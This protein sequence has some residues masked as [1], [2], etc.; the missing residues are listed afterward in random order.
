[1]IRRLL[2][3]RQRVPVALAIEAAV[4]VAAYLAY[5][6]VRRAIAPHAGP[7]ISHAVRLV[8]FERR[9][10]FFWER[11]LQQAVVDYHLLVTLLNWVYVWGYLPV[12]G[13]VAIWLFVNHR[14]VYSRYRNAFLL[15]GAAGLMVFA[16][17]P[18]APPR[19]LPDGGFV[20]T[21]RLY[22]RIYN[23]IEGSGY[24]NQFAAVPSFHFGWILLVA[25][26]IWETTGNRLLRLAA[27]GMPV[28]MLASIVL[29]GNHYFFDALAGG[30]LVLLALGVVISV[31]RVT[32][33]IRSRPPRASALSSLP[34]S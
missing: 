28:A 16:F 13:G 3:A 32:G 12:I 33:R 15:S 14:E 5:E 10:G 4:V 17:F 9:A 27:A 24:V 1:M 18:V 21:V 30:A 25:I 34:R 6:S 23:G 8:E 31:E 22:S 20:D 11:T 2:E 26:A 19:L 29:T 7:A